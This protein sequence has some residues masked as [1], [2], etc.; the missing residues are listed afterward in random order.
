MVNEECL[1]EEGKRERK[2]VEMGDHTQL[3]CII[4]LYQLYNKPVNLVLP[5]VTL[6]QT[7]D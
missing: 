1:K 5:C 6:K 2:R 4:Q 7:L 3:S